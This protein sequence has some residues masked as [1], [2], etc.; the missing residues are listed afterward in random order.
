[1][2]ESS[3]RHAPQRPTLPDWCGH[4]LSLPDDAAAWEALPQP[5]SQEE[6]RRD[7]LLLGLGPGRPWE[8]A[9]VAAAAADGGNIFWLE[10]PQVAQAVMALSPAKRAGHDALPLPWCE[11][12]VDEAM[13]LVGRCRAYFYRPGLR[14]APD[15]WGPL[16]GRLYAA[17]LND[18]GMASL[19]A[20]GEAAGPPEVA[21]RMVALPGLHSQ[22]LQQELLYGLRE[23][24]FSPC[25]TSP[26]TARSQG[27]AHWCRQL[28]RQ[29]PVMLLSVNLR[30]LDADGR[31]FH[32]C[33]ALEIP[34]AIWFV[35]NPWHQL[36]ALRLPWWREACLFV[37]D[38]SFI[39]P[40]QE[41]GA[42][43]VHLLPLAVAPH[44]WRTLP[45]A[46][47]FANLRENP[48]LFVGRSSFPGR[49]RFFAAAR[50]PQELEACA[51]RRAAMSLR[52]R[53]CPH[54]HWW[55]TQLAVPGWPGQAVR[56]A[57]LGAEN[58]SCQ[59]RAAWLRA[60][61]AGGLHVRGDSGWQGHLPPG[62]PVL[63]VVDYYG[64]LPELY[65][66][67]GAVLNV[68]SL[69]LPQ[70]LN[71]RHFDVWAAGG[72]L[73]A[74]DSPGLELFPPE[75]T[76]P[77]RLVHPRDFAV[78]LAALRKD[79]AGTYALCRAWRQHLRE[80]HSYAQRLRQMLEIVMD[81]CRPPA[82][83]GPVVGR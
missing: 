33:R 26:P 58:C 25:L 29:H 53:D 20:P 37:T 19:A 9:F 52:G 27:I 82:A 57:G 64:S 51:L 63:P 71:Q 23:L 66:A 67:A 30:G 48:P 28:E 34:V 2:Q 61:L 16:L 72:L 74:D 4:P 49:N 56:S 14:L 11:V 15:F 76:A 6:Q 41:A 78:R 38:A 46:A 18:S 47:R 5:H 70:S 83:S 31:I 44:M 73:L 1:M 43:A 60:G 22:L 65:G 24:G 50:V 7:I 62:T 79:R 40:L 59:R 35:D 68:T 39:A 55:Q 13:T 80:R 42:R 36:S 10:A 3:K 75:L 8:L 69:L 21:S 54:I 77:V 32:L 81:S 45:D 17:C 12:S